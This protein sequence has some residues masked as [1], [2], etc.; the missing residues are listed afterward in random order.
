MNVK[1][2][3]LVLSLFLASLAVNA[4]FVE[5][6]SPFR[7]GHWWD[8]ARSGHGFEILNNGGQVMVVWYTYDESGN[9]TWYTA[10]GAQGSMG[11]LWPLQKH[12]WGN[13]RIAESTT[14]G[15]L[16][17]TVEHFEKLSVAWQVG[18]TQSTWKIVPFVQ[19][20]VINEVDLTGHWYNPAQSGWGMTLLDQGDA[21]GAVIYTYDPA[22]QPTWVAG[23]HR[24]KGTRVELYSTR[25]DCPSCAYRGIAN[26]PAGSIDI[27]YRGDTEVTVRGAPAIAMAPG[28]AIDGAKVYQLGRPASTR[29]V[30]YQLAPFARKET[31]KAFIGAG[32]DRRIFSVGGSDF[33]AAPPSSTQ[34]FSSTNL[35]EAGVDEAD[36]V[37]T[38]GRR[39]FAL[40]WA[41]TYGVQQKV[42]VMD[43]GAGASTLQQIAEFDL[44]RTSR[45]EYRPIQGSLYLHDGNLFTISA[46]YTWGGWSISAP[47]TAEAFFQ[48]LDVQNP[49]SPAPRWRA[50]ISGG[51]VSTRRIGDRVYIVSRFSPSI[52]GYVSYPQNEA[53]RQ[54]N[55]AAIANA[56]VESLLP[57]ISINGGAPTPLVSPERVL[58]PQL[59]A[60]PAVADLVVISVIDLREG[61]IVDSMAIAG[62]TDTM[63]V[64]TSNIY[65]AST[66]YQWGPIAPDESVLNTDIHQVAI[67]GPTL[68][69]VGTGSVQGSVGTGDK[70]AFRF[71]EHNGVLGVLS[72]RGIWG[73]GGAGGGTDHRLTLLT[74]STSAPGLLKTV[75]W[76]PNSMRPKAI[77]KPGEDLYGT[78]FVG[79][80]LY[81]VTYFRPL[82][83]DPLYTIDL[84][85][86][87]DPKITGEFDLPGFSDYLHP[88]P[89]GLL[90]GIGREAAG[91]GRLLGLQVTLFDVSGPAP[92]QVDQLVIGKEGSDSTLFSSHRAFSSLQRPDGSTYFAFPAAI[93]DVVDSYSG[94][95]WSY[96]GLL[97]FEVTGTTPA[98]SRLAALPTLTVAQRPAPQWDGWDE[99][100]WGFARSILFQ[101]STYYLSLGKFWRVDASGKAGPY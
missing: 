35:Q 88:L 19:S 92:A 93:S 54:A 12:R 83:V 95:V 98:T 62:R 27:G 42:R 1:R 65:I 66:R 78:R 49:A 90:L 23:F 6:R 44:F 89:N 99:R 79:D 74:P 100:S 68:E 94:L 37:K 20:G 40:N 70:A 81:A 91:N 17:L 57:S 63:Y 10:Q 8:P 59:G 48:L 26:T 43:V 101:N 76:L 18:P 39:I 69:F 71:G 72:S 55:I 61:R 67:G 82:G 86:K 87:G 97:R 30:D 45:T 28:I 4:A 24:G 5:D 31:L 64:S 73:W 85:D 51:V 60:S 21:F 80:K 47:T 33:S 56:S 84:S 50:V 2:L 46:P 75:S 29:R 41:T 32:M 38:D 52:P 58:I 34:T 25:G 96:S 36:H 7:Q 15:I 77:G 9:P 22:G 11:T 3:L 53:Q 14:V 16:Q 13:G